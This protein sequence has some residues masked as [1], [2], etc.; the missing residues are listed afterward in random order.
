MGSGGRALQ[1]G[2]GGGT[3]WVGR[4]SA[5][6]RQDPIVTIPPCAE[7]APTY[8]TRPAFVPHDRIVRIQS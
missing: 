4:R 6:H 1:R 8:P 7:A 5:A 3:G 2:V